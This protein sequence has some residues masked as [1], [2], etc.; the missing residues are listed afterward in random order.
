MGTWESNW[1]TK[2]S[3]LACSPTLT[4]VTFALPILP[5]PSSLHA[6]AGTSS[7]GG[8]GGVTGGAEIRGPVRAEV[9]AWLLTEPTGEVEAVHPSI[10]RLRAARAA[11][12]T[13]E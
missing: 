6:K 2:R 3:K 11:A 7:P 10:S 13:G 8:V 4:A 1:R 9:A 5:P 12:R